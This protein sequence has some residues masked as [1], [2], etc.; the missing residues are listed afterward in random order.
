MKKIFSLSTHK[1]FAVAIGIAA[2]ATLGVHADNVYDEWARQENARFDNVLSSLRD[3]GVLDNITETQK[4]GYRHY[5]NG[6]YS[7]AVGCFRRAIDMPSTYT[8]GGQTRDSEKFKA[9]SYVFLG[10]MYWYGFGVEQDRPR[11]RRYINRCAQFNKVGR[12]IKDAID[13][14]EMPPSMRKSQIRRLAEECGIILD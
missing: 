11:A 13:D 14:G 2:S 8:I 6:D 10:L 4:R 7:A 1:K 5:L 12:V 3:D 9:P